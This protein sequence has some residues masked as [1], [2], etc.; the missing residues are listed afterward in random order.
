MAIVTQHNCTVAPRDDK[1]APVCPL[2]M[3]VQKIHRLPLSMLY[4]RN[5]VNIWGQAVTVLPGQD[6]NAI[7]D[8]AST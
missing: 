5:Q 3:Q 8:Q 7:V 2:C 1:Y 4:F 6:P